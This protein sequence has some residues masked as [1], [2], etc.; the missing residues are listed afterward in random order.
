M[1]RRLPPTPASSWDPLPARVPASSSCSQYLKHPHYLLRFRV[2]APEAPPDEIV[3]LF[4]WLTP[5]Y[6]AAL[7]L[8]VTSSRKLFLTP[9]V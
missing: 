4:P 1:V 9:H 7:Y 6:S 8:N 5:P 2:F 3:L